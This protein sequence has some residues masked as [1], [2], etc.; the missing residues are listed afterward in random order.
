MNHLRVQ[1]SIMDKLLFCLLRL[2]FWTC[3]KFLICINSSAQF[4]LHGGYNLK[5]YFLLETPFP[6][7]AGMQKLVFLFFLRYPPS[8]TPYP[9]PELIMSITWTFFFFL[10][11]PF[12]F[13]FVSAVFSPKAT[14]L[15]EF[16]FREKVLRNEFSSS[17]FWKFENGGS[18]SSDWPDCQSESILSVWP[19]CQIE[20]ISSVWP[21]CQD[22]LNAGICEL[23]SS[24][25]LKYRKRFFGQ[26]QKP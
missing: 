22:S 12:F 25:N 18:I 19:D 15:L 26:T 24:G 4:Q 16:W 13:F 3:K 2:S 17:L 1:W 20:L 11:F 5:T 21:D 23:L 8:P 7:L 14:N 6:H 10:L 9:T